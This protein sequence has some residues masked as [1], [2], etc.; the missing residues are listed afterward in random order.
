MNHKAELPTLAQLEYQWGTAAGCNAADFAQR[1]LQGYAEKVEQA[2]N[3]WKGEADRY[4]DLWRAT[5][6]SLGLVERELDAT[7]ARQAVT[8]T[9]TAPTEAGW[10]W[11]LFS[12]DAEPGAMHWEYNECHG[13]FLGSCNAQDTYWDSDIALWGPR[14]QPPSKP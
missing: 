11:I 13:L 7:Q 9:K 2:V 3:Y 14:I 10:Y 12:E 8:W 4:A 6:V 5:R 1:V